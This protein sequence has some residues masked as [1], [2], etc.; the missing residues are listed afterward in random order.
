MD[1]LCTPVAIS[2]L[3]FALLTSVLYPFCNS[4]ALAAALNDG[5]SQT[6]RSYVAVL[7]RPLSSVENAHIA[8][9]QCW[10]GELHIFLSASQSLLAE[11]RCRPGGAFTYV[12]AS[13][14][15]LDLVAIIASSVQHHN[16]ARVAEFAP[17]VS[18]AVLWSSTYFGAFASLDCGTLALC[19]QRAI[20]FCSLQSTPKRWA[21]PASL[22]R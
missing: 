6:P 9:L 11:L 12:D 16:L 14:G 22:R 21:L 8:D 1:L 3:A 17:R 10:L 7:Q 20:P 2:R 19:L 5:L 15:I 4:Q 18:A 13:A